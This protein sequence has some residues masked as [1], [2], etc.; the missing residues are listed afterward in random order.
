MN[1]LLEINYTKE[2]IEILLENYHR[3]KDEPQFKYI[4]LDLDNALCSDYLQRRRCWN[5]ENV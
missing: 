2:S 1:P 5:W 3:I 4:L